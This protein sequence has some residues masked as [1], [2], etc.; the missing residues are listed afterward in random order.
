[1]IIGLLIHNQRAYV[2]RAIENKRHVF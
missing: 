1:L 2:F